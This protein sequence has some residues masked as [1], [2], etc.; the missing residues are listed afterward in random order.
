MSSEPRFR[1]GQVVHLKNQSIYDRP[2]KVQMVYGLG[3]E[4]S[5]WIYEAVPL[6]HED[7]LMR[8]WMENKEYEENALMS[9]DEAALAYKKENA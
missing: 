2:L 5:K 1:K 7:R 9:S 8:T 6:N 4:N 3:L